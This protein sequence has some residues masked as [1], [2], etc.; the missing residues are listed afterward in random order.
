M[1][2][3]HAAGAPNGVTGARPLAGGRGSR[4]VREAA[5]LGI[6]AAKGLVGFA[7]VVGLWELALATGVIHKES[8]PSIGQFVSAVGTAIGNGA[9]SATLSTLVAWVLTLLISVGLGVIVGLATGLSPFID[10][11]TTVVFDFLRALPP[12]AL[13]PAVV[14]F[15]GI[16]RN[17]EI[18]V[19]VAAAVW[20][21]LLGAHYGVTHTD[22]RMIDVGRTMH[23][24]RLR[25]ITRIVLP[26]ALPSIITGIRVAAMIALAVVIGVEIVGGTGTG[27]GTYISNATSTGATDQAYAGGFIAAVV[28]LVIVAVFTLAERRALRWTPDHR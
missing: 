1:S 6:R 3:V 19:A 7:V 27:L 11:L 22:P 13:L 25:I 4:Y 2:A 26:S 9:I 23:L 12:I 5:D 28:G 17:L 14:L 16:G 21:V 24:G 8:A 20:P 10:A 15:A 18:V